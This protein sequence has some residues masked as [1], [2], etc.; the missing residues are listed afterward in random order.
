MRPIFYR[1]NNLRSF[2]Y[3]HSLGI[4]LS[5]SL[6]DVYM[7]YNRKINSIRLLIIKEFHI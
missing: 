4:K 7:G 6:Y 3:K 5:L 2:A 1:I